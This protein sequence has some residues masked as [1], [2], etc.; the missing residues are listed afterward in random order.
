MDCD[1]ELQ[2]TSYASRRVWISPLG[3]N[4]RM[5]L[6]FS[7]WQLPH[8]RFTPPRAHLPLATIESWFVVD[9]LR[10]YEKMAAPRGA[11]GAHR[12]APGVEVR[13]RIHYVAADG[14]VAPDG[15]RSDACSLG[16]LPGKSWMFTFTYR[17]E[18]RESASSSPVAPR[19]RRNGAAAVFAGTS[20]SA[21]GAHAT[22]ASDG[23]T[24]KTSGPKSSRSTGLGG[25]GEGAGAAGAAP[26]PGVAASVGIIGATAGP[27]SCSDFGRVPVVELPS[28]TRGRCRRT[29]ASSTCAS[30]RASAGGRAGGGVFP[31]APCV[32]IARS[33]ACSCRRRSPC[34]A[35]RGAAG[36]SSPS[37]CAACAARGRPAAA[38]ARVC[39]RQHHAARARASGCAVPP[40]TYGL[41][42]DVVGLH[43]D[44]VEGSVARARLFF[45]IRLLC[46][47]S[48]LRSGWSWADNFNFFFAITKKGFFLNRVGLYLC[49]TDRVFDRKLKFRF[50]DGS[51]RA[52][53]WWFFV[54]LGDL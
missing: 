26:A 5:S 47:F 31:S 23:A 45:E 13:S 29:G 39:L 15:G 51:P 43:L 48:V 38:A 7:S 6:N 50:G 40:S 19:R 14:A 37:R 52:R 24:A 42:V 1:L 16:K 34:A 46:G 11:G 2:T 30:G 3:L 17:V 44:G 18:S 12:R 10:T 21:T 22:G 35:A 32:G 54:Q 25:A 8:R 20:G 53:G 4:T 9:G 36:S 27:R 28:A 49:N 33:R 41:A